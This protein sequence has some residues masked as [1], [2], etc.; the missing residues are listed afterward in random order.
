MF[1]IVFIGFLAWA[2]WRGVDAVYNQAAQ[3][4]ATPTPPTYPEIDHRV[5]DAEYT[6]VEY[7][8]GPEEYTVDVGGV[9]QHYAKGTPEYAEIY[10]AIH[11]G[12]GR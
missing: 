6:V 11:K 2:L 9:T 5:V 8:E 4:W 12:G 10:T 1:V 3:T 7:P